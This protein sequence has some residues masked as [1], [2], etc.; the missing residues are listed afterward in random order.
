MFIKTELTKKATEI[1]STLDGERFLTQVDFGSTYQGTGDKYS[2]V[3]TVLIYL[4]KVEEFIIGN[5]KIRNRHYPE[6]DLRVVPLVRLIDLFTKSSYDSLLLL[7]RLMEDNSEFSQYMFKDLY[8]KEEYVKYL[9]TNEKTLDMSIVGNIKTAT[10]NFTLSKVDGKSLVKLVTFI[11]VYDKYKSLIRNED[12]TLDYTNLSKIKEEYRDVVKLKRY[13]HKQLE[14]NIGEV[15]N[16]TFFKHRNYKVNTV[17]DMLDYFI[18]VR[19]SIIDGANTL[20]D[21]RQLDYYDYSIF[22]NKLIKLYKDNF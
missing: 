2:D 3:D 13:S 4:N 10:K 6:V 11:S 9:L 18:S 8:N 22:Y 14:D 12:T 1:D 17:Q 15:N 7:N 21:T 16:L 5:T 19:Q 20:T